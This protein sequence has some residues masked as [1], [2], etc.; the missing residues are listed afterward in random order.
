MSAEDERERRR[1]ED[2]RRDRDREDRR[3]QDLRDEDSRQDRTDDQQRRS[4]EI[5]QAWDD[6]RRGN[7][8]WAL[9][10]LAGPDA[11]LGYLRAM[12]S[13]ADPGEPVTAPTVRADW[14]KYKTV[15]TLA[16]LLENVDAAAPE[17][18]FE[19]RPPDKDGDV[20]VRA[21]T[22]NPFIDTP[23]GNL[24]TSLRGGTPFRSEHGKFWVK[25]DL[26]AT[27]SRAA[28]SLERT[29]ALVRDLSAYS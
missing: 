15:E 9:R 5:Q 27:L 23:L 26:L 17:V 24:W 13:P 29:S 14:P 19:I 11:A 20:L 21:L 2:E 7:T 3:Q 16:Q 12:E 1:R 8:A 22:A 18:Q 10:G 4:E 25:A 28:T 6:L